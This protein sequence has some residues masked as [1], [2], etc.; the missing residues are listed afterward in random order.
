MSVPMVPT[1]RSRTFFDVTGSSGWSSVRGTALSVSRL[2]SRNTSSGGRS[3]RL[4]LPSGWTYSKTPA[5]VRYASARKNPAS[6]LTGRE[7]SERSNRRTT[8]ATSH[9]PPPRHAAVKRSTAKCSGEVQ[10]M[11]SGACQRAR[12]PQGSLDELHDCRLNCGHRF[13]LGGEG[14][15]HFGGHRRR[16]NVC[17]LKS[18]KHRIHVHLRTAPA[19][20]IL[21]RVRAAAGLLIDDRRGVPPLR[22][23][24]Q[25]PVA[26]ANARILRRAPDVRFGSEGLLALLLDL[27]IQLADLVSS[28]E[29][30][31]ALRHAFD[32][33]QLLGE[34]FRPAACAEGFDDSLFDAVEVLR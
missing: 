25:R 28:D 13:G 26:L 15:H 31:S 11:P 8:V 16:R 12:E 32:F 22:C 24:V 6:V 9:I 29:L 7:S 3:S 20:E 17:G 30:G 2:S 14:K 33:E 18:G 21:A 34:R 5:R 23:S 10:R 27:G 19:L 1:A 4:T